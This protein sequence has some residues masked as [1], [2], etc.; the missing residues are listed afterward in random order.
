MK[1]S[2]EIFSK[3]LRERGYKLL[4]EKRGNIRWDR[5]QII[6]TKTGQPLFG[7]KPME[8]IY[9]IAARYAVNVRVGTV[10][11]TKGR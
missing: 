1:K 6:R 10:F 8:E 2:L 5:V 4:L 3:R 11:C 9:E 7:R